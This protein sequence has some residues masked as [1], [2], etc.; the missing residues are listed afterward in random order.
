VALGGAGILV[1]AERETAAEW[2]L[3]GVAA[4]AE[5]LEQIAG[6]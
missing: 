5:W 6:R 3:D 2:R 4:V 1:G